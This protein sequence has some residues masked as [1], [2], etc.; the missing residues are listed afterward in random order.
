MKH[1]TL[2]I[3][4]AF[5]LCVTVISC[6]KDGTVNES[7]MANSGTG[8]GGSLAKFTIVGNYLYTVT[9]HYLYS[10]NISNPANTV[11]V[12][13]SDMN[14]DIETIYPFGNKLFIGTATGLLIYSI[15]D[16]AIPV[17]VGEASH[18]RSCDPVVANDSIAFV[19]LKGS[20]FCGPAISGLYVHD[21]R[22]I[23]APQL[24]KTVEITTPEGLGLRGS[25]L[26]ICCN[27]A[28]LKVFNVANPSNP[29]E[30]RTITGAYF[31]DVI[32]YGDILICYVK[33][34]IMLFDISNPISPV[35]I[36]FIAN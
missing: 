35:E 19:T 3:V 31:T 6:A 17:K 16:P 7:A 13:R 20:T 28:G 30:I 5:A 32:P 25:T 22:N 8:Q 1:F 21:I 27:D 14:F 36:K 12:H 24:I 2:K 10:Y 18:A 29:I 34:G 26:Y 4:F 33:T 15:E 23:F 9:N 11:M